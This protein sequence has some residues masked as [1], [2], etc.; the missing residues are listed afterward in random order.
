VGVPSTQHP[1]EIIMA[2]GFVS[3]LATP[4]FLVDAH[5]TLVFYNEAAAELL[6]VGFEEAGPMPAQEWAGRF[7]PAAADGSDLTLEELPLGIAL[8]KGHPA[9][10]DL[11]IRAA[12][13]EERVI[14][15]TA[16]PIV[17]HEGQTGAIAIFWSEPS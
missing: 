10:R 4:A 15:V 14:E 17:G 7:A 11:R 8:I 13:G 3:N 16:F 1:V 9:H 6:G 12:T 5:G 2:R